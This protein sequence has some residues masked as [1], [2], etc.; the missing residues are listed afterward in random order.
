V[1]ER[2]NHLAGAL[3]WLVGVAAGSVY[4]V[5]TAVVAR[6]LLGLA[7]IASWAGAG[8][9]GTNGRL[10]DPTVM[11]VLI[12][13]AYVLMGITVAMAAALTTRRVAGSE[14]DKRMWGRAG[15]AI[16]IS[17]AGVF[18]VWSGIAALAFSASP[19]RL[20]WRTWAASPV[21]LALLT[22]VFAGLLLRF[23]APKAVPRALD[24][25]TAES[26]AP[27]GR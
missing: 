13:G 17:G 9:P 24:G 12:R 4:W 1:S 22:S 3:A 8:S 5:A 11:V 26:G 14:A 20:D 18:G 25:D 2:S 7:F 6:R 21:V 10:F 27:Q 23:L 15:D 16:V 19:D